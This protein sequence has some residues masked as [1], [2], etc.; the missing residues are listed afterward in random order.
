M[1]Y[2][3]KIDTKYYMFSMAKWFCI[4]TLGRNHVEDFKFKTREYSKNFSNKN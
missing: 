4:R 1:G 3:C 2:L